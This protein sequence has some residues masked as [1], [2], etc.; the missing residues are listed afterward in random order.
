MPREPQHQ[1]EVNQP[2]HL[3]G[4]VLGM[5]TVDTD[6]GREIVGDRASR[7]GTAINKL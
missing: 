6:P 2:G 7:G 3:K 5:R 1:L 4:K